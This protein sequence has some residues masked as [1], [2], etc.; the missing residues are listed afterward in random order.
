M[1][2]LIVS[3]EGA[4]V[5]TTSRR[6]PVLVARK[7]FRKQVKALKLKLEQL[8]RRD[9]KEK[10]RSDEVGYNP[11]LFRDQSNSKIDKA[12]STLIDRCAQVLADRA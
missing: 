11:Y 6:N 10:T 12:I 7:V 1:P 4:G 9:D 2:N 8:R 5:A 3:I